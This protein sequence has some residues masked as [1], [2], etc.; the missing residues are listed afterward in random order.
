MN[1]NVSSIYISLAM[2][3]AYKGNLL[4]AKKHLKEHFPW[5]KAVLQY[6]II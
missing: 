5:T 4:D 6:A 3:Y 1:L 2:I